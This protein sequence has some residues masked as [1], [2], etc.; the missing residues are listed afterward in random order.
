MQQKVSK[1][2]FKDKDLIIN[3]ACQDLISMGYKSLLQASKH[4]TVND[5]KILESKLKLAEEDVA[6]IKKDRDEE[7]KH[8]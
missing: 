7:K 4:Q 6:Q 3:Q 5:Q 2:D 1:I 8:L